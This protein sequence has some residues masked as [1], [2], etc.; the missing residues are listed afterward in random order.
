MYAYQNVLLFTY[1][2][3][4]PT[5]THT[6]VTLQKK[7]VLFNLYRCQFVKISTLLIIVKNIYNIKNLKL[8]IC[9]RSLEPFVKKKKKKKSKIDINIV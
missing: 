4:K 5:L 6:N 3:H 1:L 2:Q 9:R 8:H 7:L